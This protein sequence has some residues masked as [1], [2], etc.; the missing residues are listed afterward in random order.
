MNPEE[1]RQHLDATTLRPQDTAAEARALVSA[2]EALQG[3]QDG[4]RRYDECVADAFGQMQVP[5]E[6]RARLLQIPQQES[7]GRQLSRGR[8]LDTWLAALAGVMLFAVAGVMWWDRSASSP[9]ALPEWQRQS[10]A[11]VRQ[12]DTGQMPLDHRAGE[13]AVLRQVLAREQRLVPGNLPGPVEALA[14]LGC[15]TVWLGEREA[16]VVCFH[17][18]P[19]QEA[20][21][22]VVGNAGGGLPGAPAREEPEIVE[23][24]G[25]TLARWSREG[26]CYLIAT[27]APRGALERLFALLPPVL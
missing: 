3:W 4:Q 12:I 17:L 21:L 27:R 1:A 20:H 5:E 2:D 8:R 26:R 22:V 7:G 23:F 15:K 6:L 19:G 16:T 24:E 11:F 25:W 18:A 10:L 13:L 14:S 9:P